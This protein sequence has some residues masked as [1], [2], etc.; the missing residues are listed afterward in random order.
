MKLLWFTNVPVSIEQVSKGSGTWLN[1]LL[2]EAGN[3]IDLTICFYGI[4]SEKYTYNNVT[5]IVLKRKKYNYLF[6]PIFKNTRKYTDIINDIKPDIIHIHGTEND[7]VNLIHDKLNLPPIVVSI[8]GILT[9]CRNFYF[10]GFSP[11]LCLLTLNFKYL[12]YYFWFLYMSKFE[13]KALLNL[14]YVF[15][16]TEWDYRITKILSP[17]AQYFK[18]GE[19][20]RTDFYVNEWQYSYQD[21]K[22][23]FTTIGEALYK[24]LEVMAKSIKILNSLNFDFEWRVAGISKNS[25]ILKFFNFIFGNK[26]PDNI[27]FLGSLNSKEIVYEMLK[28]NL[29]VSTSHIENSSNSLCEALTLGMPCISTMAGG[30]SS[31]ISDGV[32]GLLVQDGDPWVLS[33]VIID[34]LSKEERL[35]SLGKYARTKGLDRHDKEKVLA[36]LLNGYKSIYS[37]NK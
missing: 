12:L 35:I 23:I 14:N 28:S 5:F 13:R 36:E 26:L 37:I 22:I 15:G 8:Q 1:S 10:K 25:P 33:G 11:L 6:K 34:I 24:G 3:K 16:R 9:V 29:Y 20:L 4:K 30:T 27:I 2:I 31:L 32:D 17:Q 19:I 7:F 21:K 18:V